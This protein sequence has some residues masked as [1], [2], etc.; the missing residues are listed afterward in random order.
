MTKISANSWK[1]LAEELDVSVRALSNWRRRDDAP[2]DKDVA[3]W[4]QWL[5]LKEQQGGSGSG[6]IKIDGKVYGAADILDLR[7]K[8]IDQQGRLASAN[9]ELREIEVA[10]LRDNLVPETELAGVLVKT[11]TPLRRLLDALPR[12]ASS[13]ANPDSPQ[14]AEIA[15]RG[16][17]DEHVFGELNRILRDTDS[18]QL[19]HG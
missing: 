15:V 3:A 17:L 8:L 11:L 5:V 10:R 18:K 14:L 1:E 7:A 2:Q 13:A 16:A 4:R 19:G 6:R 12:L 9:A